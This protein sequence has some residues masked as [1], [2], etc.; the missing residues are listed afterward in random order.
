MYKCINSTVYDIMYKCIMPMTCCKL[1][2]ENCRFCVL[3]NSQHVLFTN[4]TFRSLYLTT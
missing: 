4:L 2:Y 1:N 3:N